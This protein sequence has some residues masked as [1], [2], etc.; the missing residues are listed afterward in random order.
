MTGLNKFQMFTTAVGAIQV[1]CT[2]ILGTQGVQ[3]PLYSLPGLAIILLMAIQGVCI[4][5]QTQ[6]P[7]W[8]QSEAASRAVERVMDKQPPEV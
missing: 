5:V 3:P 6:L 2:I 7:S 1:A 8:R 4:F